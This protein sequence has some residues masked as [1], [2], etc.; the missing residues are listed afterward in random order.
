MNE[1]RYDEA[2]KPLTTADMAFGAD[3]QTA[4]ATQAGPS[5]RT[6]SDVATERP[7]N[8]KTTGN[9]FGNGHQDGNG[10][11]VGTAGPAD[12]QGTED[13]TR[14]PLLPAEES[15]TLHG[16]W[17]EIQTQFVD[18]PR[19]AVEQADSLVAE[20]MQ[21]LAKMFADERNGLEQQWGKGDEV[22]TED[23]RQALRRYRS[24]FERLLSV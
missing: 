3:R 8:G 1:R 13:S 21:R 17:T 10:K 6:D 9:G 5:D 20:L 12:R 16:R 19:Q 24:F 18:E 14:A 15:G 22:S 11:G 23:L 4:T 7:E 2:S